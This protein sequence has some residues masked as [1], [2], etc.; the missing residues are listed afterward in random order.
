M[1]EGRDGGR[2][3]SP[4]GPVMPSTRLLDELLFCNAGKDAPAVVWGSF[5]G[6]VEG[7]GFVVCEVFAGSRRVW[8]S[9]ATMAG[10]EYVWV[11]GGSSLVVMTNVKRL[12]CQ[13][14][15]SAATA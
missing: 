13:G 7:V 12:E 9:C 8:S 1:D 10:F 11:G 6:F 3:A 5:S 4:A 15:S 14:N 2:P